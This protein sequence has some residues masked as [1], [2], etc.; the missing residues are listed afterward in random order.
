MSK[1]MFNIIAS[2]ASIVGAGF[3][4]MAWIQSGLVNKRMKK[5]DLRK[6]QKVTL[7]LIVNDDKG[8][9]YELPYPL[10]RDEFTRAEV[11]GRIGMIKMKISGKRFEIA[12]TNTAEFIEK[13]SEIRH[14]SGEQRLCV[15]CTKSEY[16]QFSF[17]N[18]RA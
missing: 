18:G 9:Q 5:E 14:G 6:N 16:E 17:E 13:I 7:L 12:Y 10:R 2:W 1:E 8:R 3:A 11:L 15:L 4:L